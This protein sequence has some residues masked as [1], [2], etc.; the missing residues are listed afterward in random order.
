MNRHNL[1]SFGRLAKFLKTP[2][3][4][5]T[6]V[7]TC[8]SQT[9]FDNSA[10]DYIPQYCATLLPSSKVEPSSKLAGPLVMLTPQQGSV[11]VKSWCY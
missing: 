10:E 11:K 1:S 7:L 9:D 4:G 6:N 5:C 8:G 2:R 3:N